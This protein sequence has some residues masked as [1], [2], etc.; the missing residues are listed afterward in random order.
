MSWSRLFEQTFR[1]DKWSLC[2]SNVSTSTYSTHLELAADQPDTE[3]ASSSGKQLRTLAS[4]SEII[5]CRE[6]LQGI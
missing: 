1:V 6:P 3:C 4:L 2:R 5:R